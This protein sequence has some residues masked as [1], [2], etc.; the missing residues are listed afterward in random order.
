MDIER[1]YSIADD[2]RLVARPVLEIVDGIL[3]RESRGVRFVDEDVAAKREYAAGLF[4]ALR[5]AEM[6]WVGS[7]ALDVAADEALLDAFAE[8]GCCL[9]SVEME[10]FRGCRM[11]DLYLSRATRGLYG[12]YVRRLRSRG[13]MVHGQFAFGCDADDA[14]SI[15]ET[16]DWAMRCR[17][18]AATFHILAPEQGG[19]RYERAER[20]WCITERDADRYDGGRAMFR[21][22]RMIPR[23][24][25]DGIRRA[26]ARFY[27]WPMILQRAAADSWARVARLMLNAECGAIG[28]QGVALR[29]PD[30]ACFSSD[31]FLASLRLHRRGRGRMISEVMSGVPNKG[32][33]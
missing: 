28:R 9:L 17:L 27:S 33:A 30:F 29:N 21:S 2:G 19:M 14:E 26:S 32:V 25:L 4:G 6:V 10:L 18:D 1:M 16:V 22:G 5:G 24:I 15:E 20:E 23:E 13:I 7:A 3:R 8:S 31:V 11:G 12:K